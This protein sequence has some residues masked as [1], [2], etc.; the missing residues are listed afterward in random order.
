MREIVYELKVEMRHVPSQ[1]NVADDC[2]R[3]QTVE[4]FVH[5]E[6]YYRGPAFLWEAPSAWP[7]SPILE[8]LPDNFP[9][10]R[11]EASVCIAT[12]GDEGLMKLVRRY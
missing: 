3:G 11:K 8:E 6:R 5:N 7:R 10:F 9:E 1:D 4:Q 2:S 12:A